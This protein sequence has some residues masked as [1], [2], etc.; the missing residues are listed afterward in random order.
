MLDGK[1]NQTRRV[2]GGKSDEDKVFVWTEGEGR[3]VVECT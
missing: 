2:S 1:M 3:M